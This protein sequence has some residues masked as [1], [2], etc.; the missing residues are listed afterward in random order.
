MK[1]TGGSRPDPF[2]SDV[3]QQGWL[4]SGDTATAAPRFKSWLAGKLAEPFFGESVV[5]PQYWPPRSA[6]YSSRQGV[7]DLDFDDAGYCNER[8]ALV[9]SPVNV[10]V[11]RHTY[12]AIATVVSDVRL[13]SNQRGYEQGADTGFDPWKIIEL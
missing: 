6:M 7:A 3:A 1:T 4:S 8:R 5:V 11:L 9:G 10:W 12:E 2:P 13:V